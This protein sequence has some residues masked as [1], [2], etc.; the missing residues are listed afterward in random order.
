M[1]QKL[2]INVFIKDQ[3]K[4]F[5]IVF[6]CSCIQC[7]RQNFRLGHIGLINDE[8]FKNAIYSID[9]GQNDIADSFFYFHTQVVQRIPSFITEIKNFKYLKKKIIHGRVSAFHQKT[10]FFVMPLISHCFQILKLCIL[11][12]VFFICFIT[13]QCKYRVYTNMMERISGCTILGH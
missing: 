9:M 5:S 10:V 6:R 3:N 8:E 12:L 4:C 1:N 13:F 7:L 11:Y 2:K